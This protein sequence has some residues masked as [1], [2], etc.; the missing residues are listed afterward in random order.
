MSIIQTSD[1]ILPSDPVTIKKIKDVLFEI[2][3]SMTRSEGEREYQTEAIK[4]LAEDTE[5]PAKY[6]K[7][8]ARI[9]HK[10]VRDQFEAEQESSIELYDCIFK[11]EVTSPV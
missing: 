1:I 3:A 7:K 8:I 11:P 10:S 6:L 4:E 5:I 9:Y 2:S